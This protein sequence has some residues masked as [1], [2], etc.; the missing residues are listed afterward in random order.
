[1]N[2]PDYDRFTHRRYNPFSGEWVLVSPHRAQRPWDVQKEPLDID[3]VPD[4]KSD[5]YLCPT[6]L[7]GYGKRNPDYQGTFVFTNDYPSMLPAKGSTAEKNEA[8][9]LTVEPQSGICRVIC[10]SAS[11]SLTISRMNQ[12]HE[13]SIIAVWMKEY[14]HLGNK[15]EINNV[16]TFEN[17]RQIMGW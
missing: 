7:R 15:A 11:G 10:Y 1:M 4:Y 8:D 14:Q 6:N 9:L 12:S 2:H 13:I 16:Q 3:K 17:R 5:C